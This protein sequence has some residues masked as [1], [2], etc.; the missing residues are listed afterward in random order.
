MTALAVLLMQLSVI[1]WPVAVR[2]ARERDE[3]HG[4]ERLLAEL[5]ETHRAPTDPYAV[6]LKRFRQPA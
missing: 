6:P 1:F 3:R 4:I 2:M 5:S